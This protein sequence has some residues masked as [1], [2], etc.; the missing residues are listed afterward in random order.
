MGRFGLAPP[1]L[2]H[3]KKARQSLYGSSPRGPPLTKEIPTMKNSL[4]VASVAALSLSASLAHADGIGVNLGLR[5]GYSIALGDADANSKLSDGISG[6]IPLHLDAT[7]AITP[8]INAGLY[9]GYGFGMAGSKS[10][11]DGVTVNNSTLAYGLQ[12]NMLFPSEGISGWAGVFGGLESGTS[13]ASQGSLTATST[14]SGW[15][16][17]VQGGADWKVAPS[18]VVGPFA[19]LAFGQY[20]SLK[21]ESPDATVT[22]DVA[23]KGTH[24]W[25]TIG[26]RGSY[27]L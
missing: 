15:Q 6:A 26:V 11:P 14:A 5:T 24:E 9:F 7:Y 21:I 22:G 13:K 23:D 8:A 19:S 2:L 12:A 27:G 18:F 10:P 3:A 25:L 4:I 17:G 20:G 1:F 16:A